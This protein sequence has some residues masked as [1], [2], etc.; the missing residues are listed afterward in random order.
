M[1][2]RLWCNVGD[3]FVIGDQRLQRNV[4]WSW[5]VVRNNRLTVH[6]DMAR[7][8]VELAVHTNRGEDNNE[9]LQL[10]GD[11]VRLGIFSKESEHQRAANS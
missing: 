9:N 8:G 1:Q 10:R 11:Q 4:F 2:L 7:V 5:N 6:W 3:D